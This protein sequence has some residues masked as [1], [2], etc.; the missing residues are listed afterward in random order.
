M[1]WYIISVNRR[2]SRTEVIWNFMLWAHCFLASLFIS[3]YFGFFCLIFGTHF[4]WFKLKIQLTI[5]NKE[6]LW[7]VFQ[8]ILVLGRDSAFCIFNKIHKCFWCTPKW[9]NV[10]LSICTVLLCVCLYLPDFIS[11]NPSFDPCLSIL[12]P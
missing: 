6:L 12:H 1:H 5:Q 8:G 4:K 10:Y 3:V 7:H 11:S 2:F 9:E